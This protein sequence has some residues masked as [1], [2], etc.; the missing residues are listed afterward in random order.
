METEKAME[1]L[2]PVKSKLSKK[3][4]SLLKI[5]LE[6]ENYFFPF[7]FNSNWDYMYTIDKVKL[8]KI[9]SEGFWQADYGETYI[10]DDIKFILISFKEEIRKSQLIENII[11]NKD[12]DL[13]FFDKLEIYIP[14]PDYLKIFK[15]VEMCEQT[16]FWETTLRDGDFQ[17]VL[18]NTKII[19][20]K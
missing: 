3:Q 5:F 12:D 14:Y 13:N 16:H 10:D 1:I 15:E 20:N 19:C 11:E 7:S 8:V 6:S 18:H 2:E 17:S 4:Y 9:L